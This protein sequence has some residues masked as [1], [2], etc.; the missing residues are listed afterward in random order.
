MFGFKSREISKNVLGLKSISACNAL[1]ISPKIFFLN[2]VHFSNY[3]NVGLEMFS[4][5]FSLVFHVL[6]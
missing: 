1:S 5:K 2:I 3:S 6:V 4:I